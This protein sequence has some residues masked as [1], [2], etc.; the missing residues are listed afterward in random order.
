MSPLSPPHPFRPAQG[1]QDHGRGLQV[2]P[3]GVESGSDQKALR[4]GLAEAFNIPFLTHA[5]HVGLHQPQLPRALPPPPPPSDVVL[6]KDVQ[7]F[8]CSIAGV[9]EEQGGGVW[10]YGINKPRIEGGN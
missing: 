1:S 3:K 4:A 8:L 9:R 5:T 6:R 7:A 10:S 2:R